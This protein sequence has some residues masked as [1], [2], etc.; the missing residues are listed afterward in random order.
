VNDFIFLAAS[1]GNNKGFLEYYNRTTM[2]WVPLCDDR[3]TERNAQVACRELGFG[4]LNV[5]MDHGTRVEYHPNSLTRIWSW[6]EP[7]QCI[8]NM[9]QTHKHSVQKRM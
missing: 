5:Y 8:G 3:F 4:S 2:Q 9:S 7:L 6:P 1:S